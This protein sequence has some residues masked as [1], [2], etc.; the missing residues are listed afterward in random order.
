MIVAV[1]M[2]VDVERIA[3]LVVL[4]MIVDVEMTVGVERIAALVVMVVLDILIA[5]CLLPPQM[6]AGGRG[7]R[8]SACADLTNQLPSCWVGP[9]IAWIKTM[10]LQL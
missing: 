2:M 7:A 9:R 8:V 1:E 5:S 3:A 6:P 4:E 10:T